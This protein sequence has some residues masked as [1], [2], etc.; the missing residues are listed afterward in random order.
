VICLADDG[1]VEIVPNWGTFRKVTIDPSVASRVANVRFHIEWQW[2][3]IKM[4]YE[5]LMERASLPPEQMFSQHMQMVADMDFLAIMA[6]RFLRTSAL[7]R[8][9]PSEHQPQLKQAV[10]EFNQRWRNLTEIRNALGH[11]DQ[12]ALFPVPMHGGDQFVFMWPG[13]NIDLAKLFED[14]REILRA[15][16][17]IIEPLEAERD[18]P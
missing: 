10:R 4:Q 13:G 9:I 16:L 1:L 2:P 14:A 15:I 17:N 5:R 12:K 7:A 18:A 3:A 8:K 11:F 6:R